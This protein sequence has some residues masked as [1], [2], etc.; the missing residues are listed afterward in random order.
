MRCSVGIAHKNCFS[1]CGWR[2]SLTNRNAVIDLWICS[3]FSE[4]PYSKSAHPATRQCTRGDHGCL[5]IPSYRGRFVPFEQRMSR[6]FASPS[7]SIKS[8]FQIKLLSL[9]QTSWLKAVST[10]FSRSKSNR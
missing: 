8:E 5:A 9:T 6:D 7:V 2:L 10:P 4:P 1:E 3:E